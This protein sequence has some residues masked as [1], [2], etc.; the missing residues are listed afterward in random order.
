MRDM[1][2]REWKI[3]NFLINQLNIRDNYDTMR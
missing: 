3:A 2:I 1:F